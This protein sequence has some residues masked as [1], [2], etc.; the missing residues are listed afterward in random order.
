MNKVNPNDLPTTGLCNMCECNNECPMKI[1]LPKHRLNIKLYGKNYEDK[2]P[3]LWEE[4]SIDEPHYEG[5]K[6]IWCPLYE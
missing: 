2:R 5:G 4:E 6:I 1:I 3:D